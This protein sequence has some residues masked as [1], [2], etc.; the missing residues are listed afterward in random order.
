MRERRL[1]PHLAAHN[2]KIPTPLVGRRHA[3]PTVRHGAH[4][5]F[6]PVHDGGSFGGAAALAPLLVAAALPSDAF[7]H[8]PAK[9]GGAL[10][11]N[12]WWGG[13]RV[14]PGCGRSTSPVL[15]EM[16]QQLQISICAVHRKSDSGTLHAHGSLRLIDSC[17]TQ[18][19]AQGPSRTCNESKE[20][21]EETWV[22]WPHPHD[23]VFSSYLGCRSAAVP[24]H[25]TPPALARTSRSR[26]RERV[27][28]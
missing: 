20:E 10:G 7:R 23:V 27:L 13:C 26:E 28:Y 9:H 17:I 24:G 5:V 8:D 6:I 3:E 4:S 1:V 19:K 25:P 11:T 12:L 2:L 14:G 16:R 18:L 22:F 21:E 15:L